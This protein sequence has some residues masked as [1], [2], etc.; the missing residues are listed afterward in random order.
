M[1]ELLI[2]ILDDII[3]SMYAFQEDKDVIWGKL[4]KLKELMNEKKAGQ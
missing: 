4:E 2:E 1:N 3:S